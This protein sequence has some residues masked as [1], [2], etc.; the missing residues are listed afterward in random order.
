MLNRVSVIG[1]QL[2]IYCKARKSDQGLYNISHTIVDPLLMIWSG[3]WSY[4]ISRRRN[5]GPRGVHGWCLTDD[6]PKCEGASER[7]GYSCPAREWTWSPVRFESVRLAK[8]LTSCQCSRR[9]RW[10]IYSLLDMYRISVL[11][12]WNLLHHAMVLMHPALRFLH[13]EYTSRHFV[14]PT[15]DPDCPIITWEKYSAYN[16]F[17]VFTSLTCQSADASLGIS[18][19]QQSVLWTSLRTIHYRWGT[20]GPCL[21]TVY[22][23]SAWLV[24]L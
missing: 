13:Q 11:G 10:S 23:L 6:H 21:T 24:Y 14:W 20:F 16:L 17:C 18:D 9:L 1:Y 5:A 4:W 3:P 15:W 7:G 12:F 8:A 2:K 19:L 22:G